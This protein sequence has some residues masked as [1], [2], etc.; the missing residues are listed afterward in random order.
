MRGSILL[1]AAVMM[2]A[3]QDELRGPKDNQCK[4]SRCNCNG[5]YRRCLDDGLDPSHK[6]DKQSCGCEHSIPRIYVETEALWKKM[7]LACWDKI[8]QLECSEK[9]K[10]RGPQRWDP[11]ILPK[12]LE[13]AKKQ[14]KMLMLIGNTGG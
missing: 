7:N 11:C 1:F 13:E 3:A 4:N 8:A 2:A 12:A 6:C 10:G 5:T 9:P 14:N